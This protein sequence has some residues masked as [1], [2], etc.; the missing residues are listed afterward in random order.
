MQSVIRIITEGKTFILEID[1]IRIVA[2]K[3]IAD[4][5]GLNAFSRFGCFYSS[6]SQGSLRRCRLC[7]SICVGLSTVQNELF[8]CPLG[9]IFDSELKETA[10]SEG[11]CQSKVSSIHFWNN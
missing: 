7:S 3:I 8:P 6:P 9:Q 5:F 2:R 4:F 10:R 11:C 1:W